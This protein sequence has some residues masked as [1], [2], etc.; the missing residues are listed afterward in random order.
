MKNKIILGLILGLL[1]S[2]TLADD[3][4]LERSLS[5]PTGHWYFTS[6]SENG[7]NSFTGRNNARIIDIEKRPN[8]KN[9][10]VS[11]VRN[12]GSYKVNGW[13]WYQGTFNFI[14][15]KVEQHRAR[16]IDLETYKDSRGNRKYIAVMVKTA[17][18]AWWWYVGLTAGKL[19]EKYKE[20][21]ARIVDIESY[22]TSQ[23]TRY[24][25]VMI[26][27][28]GTDRKGWWY[29]RN[30]K[31]DF[32]RDKL[33]KNRAR[34][35]DLDRQDNGKFNVVM[36]KRD[37]VK[38]WWNT[39]RTPEQLKSLLAQT[40]S[41]VIDIEPHL[42]N[43]K[44][45][46]MVVSI[47]NANTL[48]KRVR[49][50]FSP[51]APGSR[52]GFYLKNLAGGTHANVRGG[53]NFIPASSMKVIV[54]YTALRRVSQNLLNLTTTNR[55]LCGADTTSSPGNAPN[56]PN[57]G[58]CPFS[59]NFCESTLVTNMR[60]Q[61]LL[62]R[63]MVQSNNRATQSVHELVTQTRINQNINLLGMTK[64]SYIERIGCGVNVCLD[65]QNQEFP[66]I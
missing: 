17:P 64:S 51:L 11:M 3:K 28:T 57:T 56:M 9:F 52:R 20:K 6:I 12:T 47:D 48:E 33:S 19:K 32:L 30:V 2:I 41:R 39:N 22:K 55:T 58:S 37:G 24:L 16:I 61:T 63:M 36:V 59:N 54:H 38:T 5:K 65:N 25:A 31:F 27:N 1:S 44:L 15:D 50:F 66:L 8:S 13:W 34:I 14:K 29:Y 62:S 53:D 49:D 42:R 23:G 21:K 43:G 7:I 26:R 45:R 46:Y 10:S 18:K 60:L 40:K 4:I 35:L